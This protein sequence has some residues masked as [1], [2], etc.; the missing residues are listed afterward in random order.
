M[1]S[2]RSAPGE[3]ME[4]P[5]GCRPLGERSLS[6]AAEPVGGVAFIGQQ[7][8]ESGGVCGFGVVGRFCF[9]GGG[10]RHAGDRPA[11]PHYG[12]RDPVPDAR[13][14]GGA[15]LRGR[16]AGDRGGYGARRGAPLC[17]TGC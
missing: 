9:R 10:A 4:W 17:R 3:R 5:G 16:R 14:R 15:L 8:S 11:S 1:L 7:H 2:E 6:G 13:F 12:P